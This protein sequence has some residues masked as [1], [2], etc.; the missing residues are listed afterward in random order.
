MNIIKK[1]RISA[2]K[3]SIDAYGRSIEYAVAVYLMDEGKFPENISQLTIEYT[4]DEVVCSTAKLNSDSSV[5]LTGCTVA[6]RSVDYTYGT[7][8]NDTVS[9]YKAYQVGDTVTYNNINYYVIENSN[10]TK[11]TV[12]I[13]KADPLSVADVNRYGT[14]H[15]N[16]YTGSS[17]GTA[18]EYNGGYGG[19]A[20]YTSET[21]GSISDTMVYD[22]C[23]TNYEQSE[24]KYAV[25]G[26]ASENVPTGLQEARLITIEELRDN[27]GFVIDDS[28]NDTQYIPS[29]TTPNW[30]YNSNYY[31]WTMSLYE[32]SSSMVWTVGTAGYANEDNVTTY[33]SN[34][35]RPVIT[36]SKSVLPNN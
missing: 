9:T 23:T 19:M 35:V 10:T 28:S 26:W 7:E 24:I 29:S 33:G 16:R 2:D 34:V 6:G 14:G 22:G 31:Y 1:A 21:C 12:T 4:G 20:Y 18:Y 13:L 30:V 27:L 11:S 17:V 25:D 32:G 8:K 5:Y 36:V 3:R 15:I